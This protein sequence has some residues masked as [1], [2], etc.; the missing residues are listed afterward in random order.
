MKHKVWD[1]AKACKLGEPFLN[2]QQQEV[3]EFPS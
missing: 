1:Y 2:L 3:S